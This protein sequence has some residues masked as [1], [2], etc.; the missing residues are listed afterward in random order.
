MKK[1]YMLIHKNRIEIFAA[2][3]INMFDVAFFISVVFYSG[4]KLHFIFELE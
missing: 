4:A 3:R 1:Y 2:L